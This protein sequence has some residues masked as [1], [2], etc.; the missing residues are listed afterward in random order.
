MRAS[1]LILIALLLA[2]CSTD[3]SA[4][5]REELAAVNAGAYQDAIDRSGEKAAGVELEE[6]LRAA[7]HLGPRPS[8]PVP[9]FWGAGGLPEA[10]EEQSIFPLPLEN[11]EEC[12]RSRV[13]TAFEAQDGEAYCSGQIS[14]SSFIDCIASGAYAARVAQNLGITSLSGK[15]L[16]NNR[17]EP[18]VR[19]NDMLLRKALDTCQRS[20]QSSFDYCAEE[21]ALTAM[22]LNRVDIANCPNG[23]ARGTCIGKTGGAHFVRSRLVLIF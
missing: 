4:Q 15:D 2:G 20:S 8:A 16:W 1:G 5:R 22:E 7:C 10:G 11:R 12:V 17:I 6:R 3:Q 9:D 18:N 23:P 13:V 19:V 21:L 14:L